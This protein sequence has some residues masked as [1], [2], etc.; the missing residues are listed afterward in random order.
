MTRYGP[1]TFDMGQVD[2]V[3]MLEGLGIRHVIDEGAEV[4]YSCPFAGHMFGDERPSAYMNRTTT[5]FFCHGCKERGNAVSFIVQHARVTPMQA[6]RALKERYGSFREPQSGMAKE[7]EDFFKD[8]KEEVSNVN[9]P[10][11]E[12]LLD[13]FL[14]TPEGYDYMHQRGFTLDTQKQWDFGFDK[15]SRR[16]TIPVRNFDAQLVGFKARST[17]QLTHPKYL[18]LGDTHRRQGYGFAPYEASQVVFGLHAAEK[19]V[20]A[21]DHH[22]ILCEGELNAVMM[23][24]HGFWNCAG[25]SGSELS[26]TQQRLIR[27][28][29]ESVTLIFDT[30]KSGIHGATKAFR[31]LY[32]FMPT[33]VVPDHEGD[34]ASLTH[35]EV[36]EL[37]DNAYPPY[38]LMSAS[39]Q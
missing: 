34:P 8:A 23:H 39:G 20:R 1:L 37:L 11:G 12:G 9:P 7:F 19:H 15:R 27:S 17:H 10:L 18:V 30:D 4:R 36:K 14:M 22:L 13:Q 16:V 21:L 33:T 28:V 3:D 26:P 32:P 6:L 35:E 25:I 24:Q 2:V 31:A 38:E 29:A 5:A